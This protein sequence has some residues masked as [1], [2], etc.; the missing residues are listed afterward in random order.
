[1]IS[2]ISPNIATQS[3]MATVCPRAEITSGG[4]W[5]R[6]DEFQLK[7]E[8]KSSSE[9]RSWLGTVGKTSLK[10]RNKFL[11]CDKSITHSR[12]KIATQH[13]YGISSDFH[14]YEPGQSALVLLLF[15][16]IFHIVSFTALLKNFVFTD[17]VISNQIYW[18]PL[19]CNIS[20]CS[21][22][23]AENVRR[24]TQLRSNKRWM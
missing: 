22:D 7:E 24:L 12:G 5:R 6:R 16:N 19:I 14:I 23:S 13:G 3:Y 10:S 1:M 4:N 17:F 11:I 15:L 8:I 20:S 21:N 18:I 9:I 2:F